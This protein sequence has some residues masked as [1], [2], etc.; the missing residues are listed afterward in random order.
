MEEYVCLS[1]WGFLLPS[2]K[3]LS[4][5]TGDINAPRQQWTLRNPAQQCWKFSHTALFLENNSTHIP[6]M[7]PVSPLL[8]NLVR[9]TYHKLYQKLLAEPGMQLRWLTSLYLIISFLYYICW[10]AVFCIY[11]LNVLTTRPSFFCIIFDKGKHFCVYALNILIDYFQLTEYC[12]F[13]HVEEM[14]MCTI[15]YVFFN[16]VK[17]K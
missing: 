17:I 5:R 9:V 16:E 13:L 12:I 1:T 4:C 11:A 6:S 10:E 14:S 8:E 2:P 7:A 15:P 3:P